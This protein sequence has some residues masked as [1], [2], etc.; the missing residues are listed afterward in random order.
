MT[1]P[2]RKQARMAPEE[3]PLEWWGCGE[4]EGAVEA[5]GVRC[6]VWLRVDGL[7]GAERVVGV[8]RVR[9]KRTGRW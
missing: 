8:R 1:M 3:R 6:G 2:P 7:R 4:G 5:R 9:R